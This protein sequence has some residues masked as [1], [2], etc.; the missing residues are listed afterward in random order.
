LSRP[1]P[2]AIGCACSFR[3]RHEEELSGHGVGR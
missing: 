3:R 1:I 2:M